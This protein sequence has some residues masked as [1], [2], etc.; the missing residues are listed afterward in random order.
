MKRAPASNLA[1]PRPGATICSPT[2]RWSAVKPQGMEI[3]GLAVSV[4]AWTIISQST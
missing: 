1:S 4:M 2:G 3:A